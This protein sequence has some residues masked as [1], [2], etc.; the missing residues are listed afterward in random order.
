MSSDI[1]YLPTVEFSTVAHVENVLVMFSVY[2]DS[3]VTK[4]K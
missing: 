3:T 2:A 1:N 4:H